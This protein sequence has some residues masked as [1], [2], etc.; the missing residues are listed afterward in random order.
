MTESDFKPHGS[1]HHYKNDVFCGLLS[2]QINKWRWAIC[3]CFNSGKSCHSL[4]G[5]EGGKFVLLVPKNRKEKKGQF[6]LFFLANTGPALFR[7]SCSPTPI[8]IQLITFAFP[9]GNKH[10]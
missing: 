1:G 6:I 3:I 8:I 9:V 2:K 10:V 5:V 7:G 4:F